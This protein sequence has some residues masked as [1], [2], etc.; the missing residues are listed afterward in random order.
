MSGRADK[1]TEI[2]QT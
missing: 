2:L 1:K